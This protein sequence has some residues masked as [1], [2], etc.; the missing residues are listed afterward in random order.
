LLN[1]QVTFAEHAIR[2]SPASGPPRSP[3]WID[4]GYGTRFWEDD[5]YMVIPWLSLYGSSQDGLPG[6]ELASNLAY[7]WIEA[8]LYDHRPVSTDPRES[9]VPSLRARRGTLLWDEENSLFQHAP[10]AIGTSDNFWGRGNGWAVVGLMRAA[11]SLDKPYTGGRYDTLVTAGEIRS[12]LQS[13][14]ASLIA[15]RTPDGGWPSNLS[16]PAACPVAETSATALLTFF[17]AHGVRKGY[18]DRETYLPVVTR[19]FDLLM[20]RVDREGN[21]TGI[22]PPGVGPACEKVTSN[23]GQTNVNYGPGAILLAT[24]EMLR[25]ATDSTT[26][27][28]V[29][30]EPRDATPLPSRR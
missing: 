25:L 12:I 30:R 9:A 17:L 22:Q 28:D 16:D 18:L 3:W 7:E 26:S 20:T 2:V 13:A 24:A 27:F 29:E 8:Y 19:S 23:N 1:G 15:R 21:V 6:N 14:A 4:G 10:E 11:D 5:L